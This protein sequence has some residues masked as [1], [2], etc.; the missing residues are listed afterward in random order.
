M[1]KGSIW[2]LYPKQQ[3]LSEK[4]AAYLNCLP[5]IGQLLLNRSIRSIEEAEH[6]INQTWTKW[7]QLPNQPKLMAHIKTLIKAKASIC[8]YGDYDVDGVT[9]T[10]MMVNI[11]KHAGCNV[12]FIS[13]HRF[14]DGY[15]LNMH[16][17]HEI[18][19]KK[20]DA[21]I[22]V[23]CGISNHA[24]I[25]ELK[26][27]CPAMIVL[28]IDHHKCPET[29]PP[30]DAI[31][32]PQLADENHPAR[33]L[34]TAA[35]IDYLFRTSPIADID[36]DMHVDFCALGLI[37]DVMP[38]TKLN[39]WY[40]KKGLDAI[41]TNPRPAILELCIQAKV[42]HETIT[43]RDVGFGLG[44]RLNAPGRLGDPRPVVE[45]LLS[46][47]TISIRSQ[48]KEIE[49]LNN[50]RRNIG[51]KIQKDIENQLSAEPEIGS[52]KGIICAGQY[53]HMGVI[54]INASKLV[55]KFHKPAI[56]IGFD[57]DIARGSARSIPGVNIYK[58][59]QK[60]DAVLDRFGGHSQAAGFS[61]KPQ[62]IIEFKKEFIKHCN[63]LNDESTTPRM[64]IDAELPLNEIS[65]SLIDELSQLEPFGEA[66]PQPVFYTS[67]NLIDAKKVG[68]T[69]AHLKCRFEQNGT[70]MDGIGFNLADALHKITAQKTNIAFTVSKNDFNGKVTPQV[71]LIEIK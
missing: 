38:L 23:D 66:N 52:Q 44:P 13:P 8:V 32:N 54:G 46:T 40:V 11:L 28:I 16:R 33:H 68:K 29:L 62:N 69:S 48:I 49:K 1:S 30:A 50:K 14:N 20:Y 39:R 34:C 27:Q 21:C 9:S 36:P 15:G 61:L 22:T 17:M 37:S 47:D 18:A 45:L 12:D 6:F 43:T 55:N 63:E 53:W 65:L 26:S 10:A 57:G 19:R 67:A 42:N 35:L 7:D 56:V 58:I 71:E 60:C 4:I 2:Q 41:K 31:V 3:P 24:E 5:I 59:I 25:T 51:E 70:I 64:V